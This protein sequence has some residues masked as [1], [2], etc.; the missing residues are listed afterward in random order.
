MADVAERLAVLETLIIDLPDKFERVF[1]ILGNIKEN[2][3]AS[4]PRIDSIEKRTEANEES[5]E[6]ITQWLGQ[7]KGSM[8]TLKYVYPLVQAFLIAIVFYFK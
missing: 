8:L 6:T 7:A 2:Q 5:N 1:E 4:K 3:A